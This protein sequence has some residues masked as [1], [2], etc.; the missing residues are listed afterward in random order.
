MQLGWRRT[1]DFSNL[2]FGGAHYLTCF[3][4]SERGTGKSGSRSDAAKIDDEAKAKAEM[5]TTLAESI[6]VA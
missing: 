2:K 1:L 6:K 3:S 5:A 4:T